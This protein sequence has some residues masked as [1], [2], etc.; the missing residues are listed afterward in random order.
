MVTVAVKEIL[1]KKQTNTMKTKTV[2]LT[3]GENSNSAV[4][5]PLLNIL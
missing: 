1:F 5:T 4:S 3:Y 2:N